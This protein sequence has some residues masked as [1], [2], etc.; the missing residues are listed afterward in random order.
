MLHNDIKL[1]KTPREMSQVLSDQLA[2]FVFAT[3]AGKR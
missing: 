3:M 1:Y 2:C